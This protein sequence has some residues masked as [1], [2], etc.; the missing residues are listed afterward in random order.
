MAVYKRKNYSRAKL[1]QVTIENNDEFENCNF[2][3]VTMNVKVGEG[4]TGLK[5]S[6]NCNLKNCELPP[7]ATVDDCL[8]VQIDM[9]AHLHPELVDSG[10]LP[11][12]AA[13]CR[14]VI[15]T[16]YVIID[17]NTISTTYHYE[18]TVVT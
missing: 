16:D 4:K 1:S 10:E 9:C 14:H 18:D 2:A 12:E 7:D 5:F 15:D 8:H 11:A 6:K 17:G 3:Q 13:D